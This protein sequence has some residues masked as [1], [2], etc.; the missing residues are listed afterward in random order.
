MAKLKSEFNL[1]NKSV[2]IRNA[3]IEDGENIIE[4]IKIVDEETIFLSRE[5]G[6]FQ[7]EK[8]QEQRL[9]SKW[10]ASNHDLFLVAEVDGELAGTC[11]LCGDHRKRYVH[12]VDI[13]IA[14]K[15]KFWGMGIGKNMLEEAIKW[16]K[17]NNLKRI[18]LEVD[19]E[20]MRAIILHTNL[21]F[22]VEGTIERERR[23]ADGSYRNSYIMSMLID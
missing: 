2:L 18:E 7:T 15:K 8:E 21:G 10:N 14:I 22:H 9:I 12:R 16:G 4:H 19:T 20:N 6:E 23:L 11:G 1:Q 17:Q 3:E 5:A 13:S